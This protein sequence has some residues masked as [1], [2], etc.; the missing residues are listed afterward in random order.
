MHRRKQLNGGFPRS[1]AEGRD[2]SISTRVVGKTNYVQLGAREIA[3][4]R[5]R[6]YFVLRARFT[7]PEAMMSGGESRPDSM[8]SRVSGRDP[9]PPLLPSANAKFISR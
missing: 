3:A 9:I 5:R 8:I 6:G 1:R 2:K 7:N 4:V